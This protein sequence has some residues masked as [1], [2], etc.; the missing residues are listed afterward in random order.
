MGVPLASYT[1]VLGV[2]LAG[3][4]RALGAPFS[5]CIAE[6][7]REC[8]SFAQP[9]STIFGV[10][11]HYRVEQAIV[12]IVLR[13][14]SPRPEFWQFDTGPTKVTAI[15][16]KGSLARPHKG[17]VLDNQGKFHMIQIVVANLSIRRIQAGQ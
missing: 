6:R 10:L 5:A 3:P 4:P 16:P 17:S 7:I 12:H 9:T 2:P 8:D 15:L 14:Q 11:S 13:S 1:L